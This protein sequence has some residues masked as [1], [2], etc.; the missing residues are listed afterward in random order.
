MTIW[1]QDLF[2]PQTAKYQAIADAIE[3]FVAEGQ[4]KAEEKLPTQ[5]WLAKQLDVTVGTVGRGY[6]AAE[7]KGLVRSIVGSGCFVVGAETSADASGH[8]L[9]IDLGLN[10]QPAIDNDTD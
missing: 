8:P 7:A 1:T 9:P 4:L 3:H 6:A 2:L 5:R 10:A